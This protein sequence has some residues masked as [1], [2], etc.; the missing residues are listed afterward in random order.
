LKMERKRHRLKDLPAGTIS[1]RR[2]PKAN[3]RQPITDN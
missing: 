2:E 3:N 1:L